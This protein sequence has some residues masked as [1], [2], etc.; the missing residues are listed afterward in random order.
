MWFILSSLLLGFIAGLI[1]RAFVPGAGPSGCLSTT[2]LGI[3]GSL[4]GGL[5]G[6]LIFGKDPTD[7]ALQWS[8]LFGS[9]FGATLILLIVRHRSKR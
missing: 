6:Y 7:G 5:L 1:A 4:L 3:V 2:F 9:V 8:G